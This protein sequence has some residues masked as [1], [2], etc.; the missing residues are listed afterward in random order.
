MHCPPRGRRRAS[1]AGCL[2]RSDAGAAHG[3]RCGRS[4]ENAGPGRRLTAIERT[5]T[6]VTIIHPVDGSASSSRATDALIAH[7]DWF[8]EP[9]SIVLVTVH[10]PVP[11]LPR[12]GAVVGKGDL[13]RYYDEESDAMLKP[14]RERMTAAGIAF[15]IRKV[16]GPV[17]ESIVKAADA[18]RAD[19]I[20]MGTR[21]MS[22]LAGM[23]L[24]STATRV[25]HLARIPVVLI[26]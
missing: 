15:E 3:R 11:A 12:M 10:L 8:R 5:S 19:L 4:G 14:A 17:G 9:P 25:L 2:A 7:L 20:Y 13:E 18:A 6:I 1:R 23:A 24:G 21:G 26:H 22:A 16:V